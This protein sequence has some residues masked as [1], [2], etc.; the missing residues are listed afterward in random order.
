[1]GNESFVGRRSE[2]TRRSR[3]QASAAAGP[4]GETDDLAVDDTDSITGLNPINR[5]SGTVAS[6]SGLEEYREVVDR[7]FEA[8]TTRKRP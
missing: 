4:L 7:Y 8:I 5:Q 1:M 3:R 6:E 2:E